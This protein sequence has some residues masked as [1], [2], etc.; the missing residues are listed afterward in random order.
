MSI[1]CIVYIVSRS[2]ISNDFPLTGYGQLP[3]SIW[4]ASNLIAKIKKQICGYTESSKKHLSC[5]RC[6]PT[7][8]NPQC[9]CLPYEK[10]VRTIKPIDH[11]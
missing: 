8:R 7:V 9:G 2:C 4:I 3:T 11:R 5:S 10:N 1:Q 6:R